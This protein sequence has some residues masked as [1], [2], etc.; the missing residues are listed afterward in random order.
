MNFQKI[1]KVPQDRIGVIIGKEGKT[2]NNI[3]TKFGV[4][5]EA[6]NES[7]NIYI[8]SDRN[9][10]ISDPLRA[11]EVVT[12]IARGFSPERAFELVKDDFVLQ[13]IDLKDYVGKSSN[14]LDRVK[15]RII[16]EGGKSRKNIEDLTECYLSVYGHN[17]SFI[18]E[19]RGLTTAVNAVMML[20]KG[21]SH[22]YVYEMLQEER[23][24][25]K[26]E[27]LQLWE[28]SNPFK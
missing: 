27:K 2:K 1:L 10:D 9:D 20:I 21:T 26:L 24:K 19:Y 28:G 18:G 12:A 7:S 13:V 17:V 4:T 15:G 5:L 11:V 6:D 23:R 3:Q 14:S 16:G 8:S 25:K 22:K